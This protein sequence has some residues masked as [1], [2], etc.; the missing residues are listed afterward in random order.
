MESFYL[1]ENGA[2]VN[3]AKCYRVLTGHD[4]DRMRGPA[5]A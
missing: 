3:K 5:D 1:N 4:Y 2:F